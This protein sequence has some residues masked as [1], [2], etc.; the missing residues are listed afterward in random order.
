L[1]LLLL[2]GSRWEQCF[3]LSAMAAGTGTCA[4]ER[5]RRC[6]RGCRRAGT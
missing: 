2:R 6:W 3:R 1:L 4:I 5:R